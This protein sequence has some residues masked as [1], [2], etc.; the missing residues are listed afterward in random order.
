MSGQRVTS[1]EYN[2]TRRLYYHPDNEVGLFVR[3]DPE[4]GDNTF[5]WARCQYT[6][7][8]KVDVQQI[9]KEGC[10]GFDASGCGV[11]SFLAPT[12]RCTCPIFAGKRRY[13]WR[14]DPSDKRVAIGAEKVIKNGD[15]TNSN[16]LSTK[17]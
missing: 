5:T 12:L 11:G 10:N 2:T 4:T 8:C 17:Q 15:P 14:V 7:G 3:W 13:I 6:V 1:D 9:H 16:V